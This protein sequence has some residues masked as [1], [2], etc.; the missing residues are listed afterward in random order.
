MKCLNCQKELLSRDQKKFCSTSCSATF[1]NCRRGPRSLETKEKIR[2]SLKIFLE[3]LS[4]DEYKEYMRKTHPRSKVVIEKPKNKKTKPEIIGPYTKIYLCTCKHSGKQFYSKTV[5]QIHPDLRQ[6]R[7][8]YGYSCRFNFGIS[9]YPEWFPD[10]SSLIKKY[11][12][13]STPGSRKGIRNVNGISRDHL[14]S[15]SDGWTNNVPPE[16]IRHPANCELVPH[17]ENQSKK[18]KSKITLTELYQRIDRFNQM[19]GYR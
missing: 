7:S 4:E 13:Y 17:K 10:A 11:G 15:V 2:N 16:I 14:Y 6:N 1:N 3:K 19:Y 9:N 5:K 18:T 12:W 8:Q